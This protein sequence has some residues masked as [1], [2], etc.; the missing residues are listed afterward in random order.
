MKA[1]KGTEIGYFPYIGRIVG[2]PC[3]LEG[4]IEEI[5]KDGINVKKKGIH[6]INLLAYRREPASEVPQLIKEVQDK[7]GLPLI[8]A[9][10][11]NSF[12]R[13]AKMKELGVWTFTIGGA[14][15]EGIFVLGGTIKENVDAVLKVLK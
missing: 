6:G 4:T 13:I 7:V 2:H 8:I 5:V 14:I 15:Q 1:I 9:G 11:I 10:S 12:K 3:I